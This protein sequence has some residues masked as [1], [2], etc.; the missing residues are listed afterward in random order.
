MPEHISSCGE[1]TAPA[2][3]ITSRRARTC[4][5]ERPVRK[6]TPVARPD[7]MTMRVTCASVRTVRLRRE[8]AG[9][10]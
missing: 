8:R 5:S 7:S 1:F 2:A 9:F 10:R 6:A 3:R 4:R